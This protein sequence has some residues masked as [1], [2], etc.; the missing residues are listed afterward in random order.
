M[1]K[2][3]VASRLYFAYLASI[4]TN[5]RPVDKKITKAAFR[6]SCETAYAYG[7]G[8]TPDHVYNT[9]MGVVDASEPR[10]AYEPSSNRARKEYDADLITRLSTALSA[11]HEET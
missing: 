3:T 4:A 5:Q 11:I 6:A 2:P 8:N 10:P 7:T 9:V 1:I